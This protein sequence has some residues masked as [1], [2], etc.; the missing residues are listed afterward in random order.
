MTFIPPSAQLIPGGS[1]SIVITLDGP[2]IPTGPVEPGLSFSQ[3][4][5]PKSPALRK[6]PKVAKI[7]DVVKKRRLE[8]EER[9]EKLMESFGRK[10]AKPDKKLLSIKKEKDVIDK[11]M[12]G[13]KDDVFSE[14]KTISKKL[15]EKK[16]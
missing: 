7:S 12:P 16:K 11:L 10:R 6:A 9:R 13:K 3:S 2:V 15:K 4:N 8:K 5:V 1:I 14:L